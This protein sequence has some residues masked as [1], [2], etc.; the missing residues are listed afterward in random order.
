MDCS[1]VLCCVAALVNV[2]DYHYIDNTTRYD[3][4]VIELLRQV[5]TSLADREFIWVDNAC[6]CPRLDIGA[7]YVVIGRLSA[8][9]PESRETRL[10]ITDRS[11]ALPADAWH[12]RFASRN[13]NCRR[14]HHR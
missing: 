10:Q 8:A 11:V 9:G 7:S 3:V 12:Q 5:S 13:F 14:R 6:R 2:T 1:T 4:R